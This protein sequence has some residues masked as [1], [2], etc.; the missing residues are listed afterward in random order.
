MSKARNTELIFVSIAT[1]SDAWTVLGALAT[2]VVCATD[3]RFLR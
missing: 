1:Q 3:A 2:L